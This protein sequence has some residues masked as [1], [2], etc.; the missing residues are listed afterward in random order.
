LRKNASA[1]LDVGRAL[2][3]GFATSSGDV[4]GHVAINLLF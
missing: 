4:R 1:S 3:R 2:E